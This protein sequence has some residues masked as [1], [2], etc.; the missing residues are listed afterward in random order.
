MIKANELRVGNKL[1][2]EGIG[3]IVTVTG[4]DI[5]RFENPKK[6]EWAERHRGIPLTADLFKNIGFRFEGFAEVFHISLNG[7]R[8]TIEQYG[9]GA[10]DLEHIQYLHQFQNLYFALTGKE[11]EVKL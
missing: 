11:W 6:N 5:S 8:V 9:E 1:Y 10:F 7:A 4:Y 3:E 2:D